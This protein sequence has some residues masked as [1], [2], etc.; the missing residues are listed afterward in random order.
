MKTYSLGVKLNG[1]MLYVE[2]DDG[3][4][5]EKHNE[6][7]NTVRLLEERLVSFIKDRDMV[8]PIPSWER[9]VKK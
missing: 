1:H 9:E 5:S 2:L 6:C 4:N 3:V 8:F 7:L